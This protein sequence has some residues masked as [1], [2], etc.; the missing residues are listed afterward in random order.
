MDSQQRPQVVVLSTGG[1][2]AGRGASTL[3][4]T[5]YKAGSL[6]GTELVEAVP[7][8]KQYARVRVEQIC[9]VA[10]PDISVAVWQQLAARINAI[11]SAEPQVAGA[12]CW[13]CSTRRSTRRAT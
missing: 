3:S 4:L 9:N 11:L 8:L 1:T 2:I 6:L 12:A 7:E 5:E 10:S 13:C